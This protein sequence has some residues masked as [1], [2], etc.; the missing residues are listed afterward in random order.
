[1]RNARAL[2]TKFGLEF[3]LG[4]AELLPSPLAGEGA[5]RRRSVSE[6]GEGAKLPS[7]AARFARVHPLPQ[8]ERQLECARASSR[9]LPG[10][11]VFGVFHDHAHFGELIAEA[12]RFLPIF[13]C[14]RSSTI[15]DQ[16]LDL[17]LVN[18]AAFA[19]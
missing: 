9:N 11:A 8:G 3:A 15:S 10:R 1:M 4:E 7:P 13:S 17:D 16:R 18:S 12:I 2:L 14:P 19:L 6:A 5:E